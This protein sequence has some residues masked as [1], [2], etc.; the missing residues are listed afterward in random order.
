[1][2]AEFPPSTDDTPCGAFDG[3]HPDGSRSLFCWHAIDEMITTSVLGANGF[4]YAPQQELAFAFLRMA[5]DS[6][7]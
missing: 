6:S 2:L 7:T 5:L 4:A 3:D 1:M